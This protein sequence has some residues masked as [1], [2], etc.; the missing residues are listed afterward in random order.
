[1]EKKVKLFQL[2]EFDTWAGY[3]LNSVKKAYIKETS[4]NK[5]EVFDEPYEIPEMEWGNLKIMIDDGSNKKE[6]ITFKEWL[7]RIIDDRTDLK[8][9]FPCPF[10]STE[11]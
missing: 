8:P 10:A 2:N 6:T 5:E 9:H 1:M 4:C 3:S 11:Q 7:Q